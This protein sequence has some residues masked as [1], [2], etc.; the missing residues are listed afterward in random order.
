MGGGADSEY[1]LF[2][3]GP[4]LDEEEVGEHE[5]LTEHDEFVPEVLRVVCPARHG[6]E[7]VSSRLQCLSVGFEAR[8]RVHSAQRKRIARERADGCRFCIG[9]RHR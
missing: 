1:R 4:K 5:L 8:V 6:P 3:T 7:R 2:R 9:A